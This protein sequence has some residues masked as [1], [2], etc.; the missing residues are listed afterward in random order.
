MLRHKIFK[1]GIVII[2]A[3][4]VFFI[5][6]KF[7]HYLTK[8]RN[9]KLDSDLHWIGIVDMGNSSNISVESTLNGEEIVLVMDHTHKVYNQMKNKI[10]QLEELN[11]EELFSLNN[12]HLFDENGDGIIDS[13]DPL[14]QHMFALVFT[15]NGIHSEIKKLSELGIHGIV[16]KQLSQP[17]QYTVLMSDGSK[18]ILFSASNFE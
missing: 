13:K 4:V 1:I 15:D 7:N 10:P 11:F 12:L 16:I 9:H 18:R 17:G 6:L 2:A 5:F 14:F 8:A 3:F